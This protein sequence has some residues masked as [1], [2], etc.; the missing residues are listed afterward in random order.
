MKKLITILMMLL[1]IGCAG[2]KGLSWTTQDLFYQQK[3]GLE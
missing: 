1:F 2:F 3:L